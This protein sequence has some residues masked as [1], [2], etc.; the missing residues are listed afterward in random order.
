MKG[1]F[2]YMATCTKSMYATVS[3]RLKSVWA[4]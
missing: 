4:T 3:S 1:F 2:F